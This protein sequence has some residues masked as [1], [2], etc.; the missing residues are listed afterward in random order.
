LG[1]A[2]LADGYTQFSQFSNVPSREVMP[3]AKEAAE[4]ALFLDDGLAEAHAALGLI[5]FL[6]DYDFTNA[7]LR[8]KRAI[9]LNPKYGSAHHFYARLLTA[10]GRHE[11]SLAQIRAALEIDPLALP[12][13]WFYAHALYFARRYDDAIAQLQKTVE[14]DASFPGAHNWLSIVH[15]VKRNYSQCVAESAKTSELSGDDHI[16]Q[17]MRDSFA[18]GGWEGFVRTAIQQVESPSL[19]AAVYYIEL[20]DKDRAFVELN[21]LYENRAPFVM[22]VRSDP[23]L[24]SL[25]DDPRFEDLLKKIGFSK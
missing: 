15:L 9:E 6:Y 5:L 25:R 18:R 12:F 4:K 2:G 20:G 8:F 21:K 19:T 17:S 11:E 24:D 10:L 1:Y 16:A 23:R 14:L 3:K 22:Y 13:N 7:E